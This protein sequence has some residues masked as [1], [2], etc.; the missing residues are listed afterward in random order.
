MNFVD[1][2]FC[3]NVRRLHMSD[4]IFKSTLKKIDLVFLHWQIHCIT[5]LPRNPPIVR[6]FSLHTRSADQPACSASFCI[7]LR[8]GFGIFWFSPIRELDP[9]Q[10]WITW[11]SFL[12]LYL[13]PRLFDLSFYLF[14]VCLSVCLFVCFSLLLVNFLLA[15]SGTGLKVPFRW[16]SVHF[17][18][19]RPPAI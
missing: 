8:K 18:F 14:F 10:F 1:N 15:F 13:T 7:T 11:Y 2:N 12:W 3:H 19:F 9:I 16:L 5:F 4:R 6:Y 17:F